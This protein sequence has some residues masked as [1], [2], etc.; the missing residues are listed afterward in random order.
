M[1]LLL[2]RCVGFCSCLME[3][4]PTQLIAGVWASVCLA[5]LLKQLVLQC[6]EDLATKHSMRGNFITFN[7]GGSYYFS[8]WVI[9]FSFLFFSFLDRVSLWP[10]T[11]TI[12][13]TIL[14]PF[15]LMIPE[16]TGLK[17]FDGLL[18]I[19]CKHAIGSSLKHPLCSNICYSF[20]VTEPG[21]R[22]FTHYFQP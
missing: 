2:C 6:F 16:I 20:R 5:M 8:F 11:S 9:F 18:F 14:F 15:S 19:F 7:F 21:G 13:F 1:L 3:E 4:D 12:L 17:P 10:W 22:W